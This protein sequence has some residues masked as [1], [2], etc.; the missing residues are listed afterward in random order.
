MQTELDALIPNLMSYNR[1]VRC[2]SCFQEDPLL[3]HKDVKLYLAQRYNH[4][5]V[6]KLTDKEQAELFIE[7]YEE[8]AKNKLDIVL[9]PIGFVFDFRWLASKD[10]FP[11]C[12]YCVHDM[13]EWL[14]GGEEIKHLYYPVWRK[15]S[16]QVLQDWCEKTCCS[17]PLLLNHRNMLYGSMRPKTTM[18]QYKTEKSKVLNSPPQSCHLPITR[19]SDGMSKGQFNDDAEIEYLGTFYYLEKDQ[20]NCYLTFNTHFQSFNK[21][22]MAKE[23]GI[24][25]DPDIDRWINAHINGRLPQD[26]IVDGEYI[27]YEGWIYS[28]YGVEDYLDQDLVRVGKEKGY[29]ILI[30]DNMVGQFQVTSEV[31]D[32]RD[33]MESFDSLVFIE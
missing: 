18:K 32:C 24:E 26:L 11:D 6:I 7:K 3:M 8:M 23:F 16:G 10:Y 15:R 22:T 4:P 30:F 21:T 29:D 27:G 1:Y 19:Y 13:V 14:N 28:L 2:P 9:K 31:V 17:V 25:T 12:D 5:L 33:R 20:K